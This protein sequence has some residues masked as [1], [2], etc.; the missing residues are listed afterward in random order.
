MMGDLQS[1]VAQEVEKAINDALALHDSPVGIGEI[2]I[3]GIALHTAGRILQG[4]TEE[5]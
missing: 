3:W 1:V 2:E 4:I 5:K